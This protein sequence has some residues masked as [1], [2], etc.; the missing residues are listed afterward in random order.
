MVTTTS[1]GSALATYPVKAKA[2]AETE[3]LAKHPEYA[4]TDKLDAL[5]SNEYGRLDEQ[6]QIYLDYTGGGLHAASQVEQHLRLLNSHVFGNPH[7]HNPTSM[8]MTELVERA[9]A[10]VLTFFNADPAEYDVVFTPNAS[11]ALKLVG[12]A[13]PFTPGDE[14]LLTADNH[15]SVNGIREFAAAKGATVTYF[16]VNA[17]DMRL[18]ESSLHERLSRRSEARNRLLAYPA[19]SNF[20]GVQHNLNLIAHAHQLGWN[21]LLDAAAFAPT[22]QLDLQQIKPDFVSISFYKIFGYPT[23]VGAL[24]ARKEALAKLQRPW[25]AG[26]TISIASVKGNGFFFIPGSPAFEDGTVNYL[27][28]PAVEIGLRHIDQI[29]LNVIHG[30]VRGLSAWLLTQLTSLQ[31]SNGQ[32]MVR[33]LG[34]TTTDSRGGT[35]TFNMFDPAGKMHNDQR[36]E[37]LAAEAQI[38][39]RTGCF[40]NPGA[41]EIAHGLTTAEMSAI[42]TEGQPLSFAELYQRMKTHGKGISAIRISVGVASNFAD[43]Y[44]FLRFVAGFRDQSAGQVGEPD[45]DFFNPHK[46]DTA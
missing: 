1:Q 7:S 39:L 25:F 46:A 28:L 32:P 37:Q 16:P 17:P 13:Y 5:R 14:Y 30:R 15:N 12:E 40:C 24:L 18:D 19:Q 2:Q 4:A 44:T 6:G 8:A 38:S 26:G 10:Y 31:H 23:G 36:I 45:P 41:G 34:P 21:V 3:F 27:N 22:N 35:I 42:F 33:V 11:G 9:R 43:V 20:S 29:G